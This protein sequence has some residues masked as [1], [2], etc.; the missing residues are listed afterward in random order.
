MRRESTGECPWEQLDYTCYLYIEVGRDD[1]KRLTRG[2]QLFSF[3]FLLF[4]LFIHS[5]KR[6]RS[7]GQGYSDHVLNRKSDTSLLLGSWD[8]D[9]SF[10][11]TLNLLSHQVA[12]FWSILS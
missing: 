11:Q 9:P 10:S 6:E 12:L 7:E 3:F 2:M 8:N 1:M 5:F 4:K